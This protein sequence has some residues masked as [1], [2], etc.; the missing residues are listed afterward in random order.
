MVFTAEQ[1]ADLIEALDLAV[2][3]INIKLHANYSELVHRDHGA[4]L[5]PEDRARYLRL[6]RQESRFR[7]LRRDLKQDA[8]KRTRRL[9]RKWGKR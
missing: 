7:L 3:A 9:N 8:R 5:D 2:E 1:Q 6:T 4:M